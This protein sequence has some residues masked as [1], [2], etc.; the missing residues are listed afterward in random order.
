VLATT[1]SAEHSAWS[2]VPPD[3]SSLRSERRD[4]HRRT[5]RGKQRRGRDL[6]IQ[7]RLFSD[8]PSK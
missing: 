7:A 3:A 6:A 8:R 5:R 2:L 1:G 4:A